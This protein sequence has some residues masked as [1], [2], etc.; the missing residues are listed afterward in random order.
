MKKE[1]FTN[2][3]GTHRSF[4]DYMMFMFFPIA[5]SIDFNLTSLTTEGIL[6][7]A[8][9]PYVSVFGNLTWGIVLGFIGTGLYANERSIG[10][11]TTY[12]V[13]VGIFGAILFPAQLVMLFGLLL[14][15]VLS[16]IFYITF[17]ESRT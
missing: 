2:N 13:L 14:A 15:F 3:I 12:L 11:I 8:F 5:V 9:D 7:V 1:L 16:V 17:I 10:T 6:R 4:R